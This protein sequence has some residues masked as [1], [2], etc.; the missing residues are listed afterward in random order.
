LVAA[1]GIINAN[2][3]ATLL[4][5]LISFFSGDMTKWKKFA[6]TLLLRLAIRQ[7]KMGGGTAKG[8]L[9]SVAGEGYIDAKHFMLKLTLVTPKVS[10]PFRLI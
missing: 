2:A 3:G 6:N 5:H 4:L 9:A 1:I 7:S 10:K 8:L